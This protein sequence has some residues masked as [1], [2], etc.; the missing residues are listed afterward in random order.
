[1][2]EEEKD[3]KQA[4]DPDVNYPYP[5]KLGEIFRTITVSS[6]EEMDYE[7]R[8]YSALLS[9]E[10]RMVYLFELNKIA[11]GIISREE[12]E[13]LFEKKIFIKKI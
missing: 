1:M 7:R 12:S 5:K 2:T 8:K 3:K 13:K 6:L 11:F 4:H 9:P 10:E